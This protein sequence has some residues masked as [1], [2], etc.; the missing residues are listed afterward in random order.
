MPREYLL[1]R[2]QLIPQPL[3]KVFG[4]FSD[5]ANLE[6]ITPPWLHFRILTPLPIAMHTG[7]LI[8]YTIRLYGVP[9][10]W[11]TRIECFEPQS[12]FVDTQIR[13]PYALWHHTH[14]FQETSNGVAMTDR[15]RYAIPYGILGEC[16]RRLFV[17]R[18]LT[19]IFDYR[20][21]KIAELLP[22]LPLDC[23]AS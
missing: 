23:V 22:P 11:R 7:T 19:E 8:D 20:Y 2:H 17:D 12:H 1:E 10:R 5:A 18:L 6:A 9:M 16:A 14:E 13:G 3:E 15:V 4:F 21:Q